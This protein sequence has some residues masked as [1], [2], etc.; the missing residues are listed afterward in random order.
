MFCSTV[1]LG[2]IRAALDAFHHALDLAILLGLFLL[3]ALRFSDT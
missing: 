2:Y 1:K 3:N